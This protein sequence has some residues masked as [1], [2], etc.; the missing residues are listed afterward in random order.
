MNKTPTREIMDNE[1]VYKNRREQPPDGRKE[2]A[3]A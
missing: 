1:I 3:S 2:A